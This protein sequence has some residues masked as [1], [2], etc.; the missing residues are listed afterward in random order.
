MH[1][2]ARAVAA[3]LLAA[4]LW[5][6]SWYPL[7]W[8][9]S[10]GLAGTWAT[11]VIYLAAGLAGLWPLARAWRKGLERPGVLWVLAL[12]SGWCNLAFVLAVLEGTVVRVLLLFYLSP[13][14]TVLLG[15]LILGERLDTRARMVLVAALVGALVMLWDH[16]IGWPWPRD[17][18]D[19]MALSSGAAFALANV[20]VRLLEDT[21][22]WVKTGVSWWGVVLVVCILL[23]ARGGFEPPPVAPLYWWSAVALGLFGITV[24]TLAVQYGVTH[25]P[26]HR[27]AVILLFELVAGALSAWWLTDEHVAAHEWLG[28]ALIVTAAWLAA[29]P[30]SEESGVRS[31]E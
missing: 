20:M 26:V 12:A 17:A 28:G 8:L 13:L 27:S 25:M 21:P 11:L 30:G 18:A 14:W 31:E 24:M 16:R 6:L 7:R 3:L 15:R 5:G 23:A 1:Q 9:D 2:D 4:T 29:R 10:G 22:L 19:W